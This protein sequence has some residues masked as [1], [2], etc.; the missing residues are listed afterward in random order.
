MEINDG[1]KNFENHDEQT[2]KT[3]FNVR[4]GEIGKQ[5]QF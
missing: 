5:N 4:L 3:V 1:K 2:Q